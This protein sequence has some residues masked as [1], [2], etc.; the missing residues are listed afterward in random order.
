MRTFTTNGFLQAAALG[1]LLAVTG[2]YSIDVA[3][4]DGFRAARLVNDAGTPRAHAVV[5]NYGW[6]LF[7][8]IPLISGNA[9]PAPGDCVWSFFTD[10]VTPDALHHDLTRLATDAGYEI[11]DINLYRDS[12]CMLPIPYVNTTF[13]ILWYKEIQVSGVFVKPAARPAGGKEGVR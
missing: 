5:S 11:S 4:T 13:G 2:C 10:N 6:Y 9:D 8:A 3:T 7:N 1:F 12:T